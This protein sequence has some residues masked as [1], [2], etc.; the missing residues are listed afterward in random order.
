MLLPRPSETSTNTALDWNTENIWLASARV[1]GNVAF[2]GPTMATMTTTSSRPNLWLNSSRMNT[3]MSTEIRAKAKHNA[4]PINTRPLWLV[5][6]M[7]VS[8][9][10]CP[11]SRPPAV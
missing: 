9:G 11:G 6:V 2:M 8:G 10:D 7:T 5:G 4:V 3:L 1:Q